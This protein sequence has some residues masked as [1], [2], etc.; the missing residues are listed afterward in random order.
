MK[1]SPSNVRRL[2]TRLDCTV[3]TR[4]RAWTNQ[5]IVEYCC[6][7]TVEGVEE[8]LPQAQHR[9]MQ[10][11]SWGL[12][13]LGGGSKYTTTEFRFGSGNTGNDTKG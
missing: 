11:S 7:G 9:K 2:L 6:W 3:D 1:P 5:T 4:E 12:F 8:Q 10:C 13:L